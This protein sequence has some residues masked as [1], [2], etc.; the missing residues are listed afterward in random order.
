MSF[1]TAL[2]M[3][4]LIQFFLII[5]L[6]MIN[7]GPL[8]E[9][10]K[11]RFIDRVFFLL[12]ILYIIIVFYSILITNRFEIW[13]LLHGMLIGFL[14]LNSIIKQKSSNF[15]TMIGF[16]IPLIMM[17]LSLI[18]NGPM[19]ITNDE[20]R[21]TGFAFKIIEDGRW[22]PNTYI[23]NFYYQFFHTIPYIKTVI[24]LITGLDIIYQLH[25]LTV[26]IITLLYSLNIYIFVKKIIILYEMKLEILGPIFFYITP[27]IT[28][29]AFTPYNLAGAF[30]LTAFNIIINVLNSKNLKSANRNNL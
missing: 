13:F 25:L 29:L 4:F 22:T 28:T 14:I 24:Y 9:K 23:E 15:M 8:I 7:F 5:I 17:F 16:L 10:I 1:W 18:I 3:F 19:P 12:F 21:F 30:F 26:I 11:I 20:G 2:M 6:N 27:A